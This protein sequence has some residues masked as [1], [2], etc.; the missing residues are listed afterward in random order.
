MDL[1]QLPLFS[2]LKR[3]LAWLGQ[4]QEVLAQNIANADT[5][6]YRPSDLREFNFKEI[7]RR[8][9]MQVNMATSESN[10]L[11]GRRRRIRDFTEESTRRPYETSLGGNAV[12]LEEQ[13]MKISDTQVKHRLANELYKKHLGLLKIAIGKGR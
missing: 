9:P 11:G 2:A 8:E 3:K 13:V 5:P 1:S 10:H 12:I 4:R 6:G 7:L